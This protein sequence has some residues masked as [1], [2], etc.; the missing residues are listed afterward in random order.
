MSRK[1]NRVGNATERRVLQLLNRPGWPDWLI[2]PHE[3]TKQYGNEDQYGIDI[4]VRTDVGPFFLQVKST[5]FLNV[6]RYW[7][8]GIGVVVA[9]NHKPLVCVKSELLSMITKWRE[10]RLRGKTFV[11]G[12]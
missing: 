8:K 4:I 5:G 3:I 7:N 9:G 6:S 11:F 10:S 12:P 2:G 1:L